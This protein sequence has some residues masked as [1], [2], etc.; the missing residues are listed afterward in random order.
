[1]IF[2]Q[3]MTV[4]MVY[5]THF[6]GLVKAHIPKNTITPQIRELIT[7]D[8]S[9]GDAQRARQALR[10]HRG[11]LLIFFRGWVGG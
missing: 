5:F 9:E 3:N 4:F 6:L 7:T 2:T 10:I 11:G 8:E 1:M